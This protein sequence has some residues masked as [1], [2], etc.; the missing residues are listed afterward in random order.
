MTRFQ[1]QQ[2]GSLPDGLRLTPTS[3]LVLAAVFV[4]AL[5]LGRYSVTG[6]RVADGTGWDSGPVVLSIQ[7]IGQLHTASFTMK[8]VLRQESQHDPEGWVSNVPGAADVVH[9]A[10][11]NEALAVAEGTVEA[12]VD[13]S[14]VSVQDVTREKR[15]DGKTVL[16]VRLPPVILY[17]P[18]VR[19]HVIHSQ[20]GP[21]WRD[22]DIVPK[23]QAR[24]TQLFQAAAEQSGIR[25]RAQDNAIQTL[26][27]MERAMGHTDVEFH[28]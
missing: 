23:A 25:D 22:E 9:W 2:H 19:L 18:V 12:G 24:A 20:N 10:T 27:A 13:L 6:H 16:H 8:D 3:L 26:Q 28:F 21:F 11:H 15:A 1:P 7:K 17:P 5:I 4:C 14:R